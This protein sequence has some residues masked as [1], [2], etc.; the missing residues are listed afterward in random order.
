[1]NKEL[2]RMIKYGLVGV[3]N[4]LITFVLF[5]VMRRYGADVD[6]ANF[7]SYA[8][9]ILNSFVW[10]KLW[11][12]RAGGGAWGRE[13]VLFL[14]GALCC[15]ALQWVAFRAMLLLMPESVAYLLGMVVY[16]AANYGFNRLI[17]FR[18]NG[19]SFCQK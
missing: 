9:G 18:K 8:A 7:V 4:T 12:F 10:N 19:N 13:A 11:V 15:W 3:M 1:M 6:V 17:T 14:L 5:F 16:T 2:L